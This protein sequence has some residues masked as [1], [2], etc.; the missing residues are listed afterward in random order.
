MERILLELRLR[1]GCPL[2]LLR[3][4][5]GGGARVVGGVARSGPWRGGQFFIAGRLLAD[6][7][8]ARPGG[9]EGAAPTPAVF[10]GRGWVGAARAVPCPLE[11]FGLRRT[12]AARCSSAVGRWGLFAQFPAP[13]K[14]FSPSGV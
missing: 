12:P 3:R 8:V 7:V 2:S 1:E 9:T 5:C 4:D 13:L 11:E 10:F 14:A 6:A